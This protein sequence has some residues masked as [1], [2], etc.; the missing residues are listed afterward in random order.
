MKSWKNPID[1]KKN[2]NIAII[3]PENII[4]PIFGTRGTYET[5]FAVRTNPAEATKNSV[6]AEIVAEAV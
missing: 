5:Y 2:M 3:K 1:L 6:M 4:Q